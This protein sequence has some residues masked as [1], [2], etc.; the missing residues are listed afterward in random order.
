MTILEACELLRIPVPTTARDLDRTALRIH[1]ELAST[2]LRVN[3]E[4]EP[5]W[6]DAIAR[7]RLR[8]LHVCTCSWTPGPFVHNDNCQRLRLDRYENE[9][10]DEA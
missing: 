2:P 9:R 6:K 4:D 5:F 10:L 1:Q 7:E 3:V 8:K